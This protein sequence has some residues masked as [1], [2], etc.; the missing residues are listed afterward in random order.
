VAEF[1]IENANT[2]REELQRFLEA[3]RLSFAPQTTSM[4]PKQM[5]DLAQGDGIVAKHPAWFVYPRECKRP[6][7]H[8]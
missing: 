5:F 3:R 6:D 7:I 4:G 2:Y 8:Q 1:V